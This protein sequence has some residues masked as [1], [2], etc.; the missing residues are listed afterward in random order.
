MTMKCSNP[1]CNISLP[2]GARFCTECGTTVKSETACRFC[3]IMNPLGSAFCV[4]CG[5]PQAEPAGQTGSMATMP[6][7]NEFVYLLDQEKLRTESSKDVVVPYGCVAIS[8][9][10][11][12]VQKVHLQKPYTGNKDN[13]YKGWLKS[14]WEAALGAAGQKEQDVKTYVVMDL[15]SLPVI[16]HSHRTPMPGLQD[17]NL[18]FELWVDPDNYNNMGLFLQRCMGTRRSLS[19]N[20]FK[21]VA[22]ENIT[23][24]VANYKLTALKSDP[25]STALIEA[26]L[27]RL[28][29]ISSRCYFLSGPVADRRHM[30][31]SKLQKPVKCTQC[32]ATYTTF[33]KFC[34]ECGNN[35]SNVDW[36]SGA[37]YLQAAGGE[38]LTLRLSMLLDASDTAEKVNLDENKVAAEVIKYLGPIMRRYDVASL[39]KSVM[40][41]QLSSELN[42]RLLRDWRGYV[43]EFS[44]VDL[45][46][47]EEEWFFKTD[48]LVAEELRKV[49]TD[50][51]F[52]A[53]D[54]SKLDLA[55]MAFALVMRKVRQDD[56][57]ELSLRRQALESRT[58]LDDVKVDEQALET[59]TEL[60]KETIEDEAHKQRLAR[61]K[62]KMLRER[63]VKR[64]M[65]SGEH[66]DDLTQVDHDITL[67]KKA[68]QHDIDLSD[69][70]GEA[71]SRARRRGIS[72]DAFVEDENIRLEA[73]RKEQLGNIDENLEDRK[74]NRRVE[75]AGQ[76][77]NIQEDLEDRKKK[78]RIEEL[79]AMAELEASMTAQEQA[80]EL[81]KTKEENALARDKID[82]MKSMDA[83]QMLAMQAA[84]LAKAGGGGQASADMIKAIAESHSKTAASQAE[85]SSGVKVAEA[86]AAAAAAAV[87]MQEKMYERMLNIQKESSDSAVEAHKSAAAVAQSTNEKSMESMMQV[88]KVSAAE[89]NQGYKEAA[90][91]SQSVNEKSMDSMAKVATAAAG[92]KTTGKDDSDNVKLECIHAD[93]D[94]VFES[95]VPKFCHKCGKSQTVD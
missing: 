47:A 40:L 69:M 26:D 20:E 2:D 73:K 36:T 71:E 53:V 94:A 91:I 76:I 50:K 11:G 57:E 41:S 75:E 95:K 93:C 90:K 49:E 46:T 31:I 80:H 78:R 87:A 61:E 64:E 4:D 83:V 55:E 85:A 84:E 30:E 13:T 42:T 22:V 10:N 19:F 38:Q 82:A 77:G 15:R 18:R 86:Q 23:Q 12:Q 88:A 14:V 74:K 70:T 24:L 34:E 51:K 63:D 1:K 27:A 9:V 68:A 92:K 28:T 25:A 59:H 39:M 5:K 66:Q 44:V 67:E 65:T 60:R 29:G 32:P 21:A 48:A 35:L 72:D 62:D 33:T 52:L 81:N 43:T 89:S 17:A 3:G 8:L 58:K 6:P 45:R 37:S 56:S 79:R 54:D 7:V 16:T